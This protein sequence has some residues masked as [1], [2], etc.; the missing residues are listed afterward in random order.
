MST[1]I[2]PIDPR[3][4]KKN[5][6]KYCSNQSYE[7]SKSVN[8]EAELRRQVAQIYRTREQEVS[9]KLTGCKDH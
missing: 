9:S 1:N 6:G 7:E 3:E 2:A 8:H 4:F 5:V